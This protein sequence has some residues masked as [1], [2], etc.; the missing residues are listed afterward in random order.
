M[1]A[2]KA[3]RPE[4]EDPA[5]PE[6]AQLRRRSALEAGFDRWLDRQLHKIY[7]PV[8]DENVPDD[9]KKLLE[10]FDERPASDPTDGPVRKR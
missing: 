1:S 3:K 9:L 5:P 8:L 2:M 4:R 7:D 6:Q 10:K